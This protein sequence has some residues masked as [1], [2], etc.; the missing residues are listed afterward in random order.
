VV[1]DFPKI[2]KVLKVKPGVLHVCFDTGEVRQLAL[3]RYARKGTV[4]EP[5]ADPK[6]ATKVRIVRHGRALCWPGGVDFCADAILLKAKAVPPPVLEVK[7]SPSK[8]RAPS[9]LREVPLP[10]AATGL[11][12]IPR[13]VS[14]KKKGVR[15]IL[16]PLTLHSS[17]KKNPAGAKVAIKKTRKETKPKKG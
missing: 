2:T 3:R 5:L 13:S 7:L 1:S 11:A 14:L 12:S 6:Y 9:V 10:R 8:S 15:A 4:F 16:T 17:P